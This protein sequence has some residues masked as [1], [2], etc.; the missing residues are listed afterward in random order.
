[1]SKQ[2][3]REKQIAEL[4]SN[5]YIEFCSERYIWYTAAFKVKAVKQYNKGYSSQEIFKQAGFNISIIGKKKIKGCLS[6]WRKTYSILGEAG[7]LQERTRKGRPK[8]TWDTPEEKLL[9]LE[10]ENNFLK[11]LRAKRAE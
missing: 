8:T 7:L 9:W 3:Y 1:M 11:Q 6:R 2:I 4:E 10:A 5:Q